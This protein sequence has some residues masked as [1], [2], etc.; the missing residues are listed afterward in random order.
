MNGALRR[1]AETAETKADKCPQNGHSGLIAVSLKNDV[2]QLVYG[3]ADQKLY[4]LIDDKLLIKI[5]V[6]QV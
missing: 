1:E 3:L 4:N 2:V 6:P 5:F